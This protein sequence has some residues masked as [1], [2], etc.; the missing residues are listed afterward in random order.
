MMRVSLIVAMD[1]N[2][3]IGKNNRLPWRLPADLRRF[4]ETT[5][6][7]AL[8]M[9]RKTYES[10]GRALPGRK[11]IVL[12]KQKGFQPEGCFTASSIEEAIAMAG[13]DEE[14][15]VIGGAQVFERALPL[16]HRIYLTLIEDEFDGDVFFPEFDD[17]L[18]V[19]K[20]RQSFSA[21]RENPFSY[22]FLVLDRVEI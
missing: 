11:N 14:V 1:K 2:R 15:F 10:I 4:K 17:R 22:T 5:M 21:D 7:H 3:V 19:E 13:T 6:R 16:A 8:I 18:W 20:D 9:G 12:T